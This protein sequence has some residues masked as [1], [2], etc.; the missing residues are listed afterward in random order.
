MGSILRGAWMKKKKKKKK[1]QATTLL[2]LI[3]ERECRP[4]CCRAIFDKD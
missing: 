3:M 4:V 1:Q 2:E